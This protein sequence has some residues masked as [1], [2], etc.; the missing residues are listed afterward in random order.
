MNENPIV[1]ALANP[2]PEISYEKA[3]EARK[4]IIMATGRSD[5]PNQV[6]NVLGF[7]YIFRGALDVRATKINEEMKLAAVKAIAKLAKEPIPEEVNIVFS[8]KKIVFGKKYIIPKP[9]DHR[10]LWEVSMAVA[11]AAVDSG[12]ASQ[13]IK[14]WAAYRNELVHRM[15]RDNKL[16]RD[17]SRIAKQYPKKVVFAEGAS[18]PIL[19]A[20]LFA[21]EEDICHPI[22]LGNRK[23]IMK[24]IKEYNLELEDCEIIDLYEEKTQPL[25]EKFSELIFKERQRKGLNKRE[26]ERLMELRNYFAAMMVEHGYADAAISG[27]TRKYKDVIRPALQIIGRDEGVGKLAGMYILLTNKGP[28]FFADTTMNIT[29]TAEELADIAI[30]VSETIGRFNV[31]PRVA[32]LSYSNFGSSSEDCASKVSRATLIVKERMPNLIIDGEI[33]AN[34]AVNAEL[35]KENFPFS[36]LA[37]K[38][39]NTFIFPNLSAGNIAYK[40]LQEM[41]HVEAIGPVLLGLDKSYHVL[42]LG[43]SVREIHNMIRIAVMDAHFKQLVKND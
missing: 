4:D 18:L 12:V 6:N 21:K 15:G 27:V 13:P 8:D 5:N 26:A 43:S 19:K 16:I 11:K 40:L 1:F 39:A 22:L 24:L 3:M 9:F 28:M 42:Q 30:L 41:L 34:F 29:P 35:T 38:G 36:Q 7:P 20:A 25:K 31:V 23:K 10:L 37:E 33:Q 2:D 32:M 14:D 17:V